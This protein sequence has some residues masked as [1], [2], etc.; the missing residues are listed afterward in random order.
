VPAEDTCTVWPVRT[1]YRWPSLVWVM[2][3]VVLVDPAGQ[4][5][6]PGPDLPPPATGLAVPSDLFDGDGDP[7]A[8]VDPGP[9]LDAEPDGGTVPGAPAPAEAPDG[10]PDPHPVST[11][12]VSSA[13]TAVAAY[14]FTPPSSRAGA[15]MT[16]LSEQ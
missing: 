1:Q 10:D 16:L 9:G 14:S 7:S 15:A 4:A 11:T 6:H 5:A 8:T 3:S 2:S 13:P 12:P